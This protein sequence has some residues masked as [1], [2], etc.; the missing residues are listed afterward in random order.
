MPALSGVILN[1]T[2]VI[3]SNHA[4]T[5]VSRSALCVERAQARR[6]SMHVETAEAHGARR[7]E[8]AGAAA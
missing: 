1:H 2:G 6:R 8:E 7:A 4:G 3:A 5:R